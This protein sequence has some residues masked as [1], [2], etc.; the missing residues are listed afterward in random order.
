MKVL[1]ENIFLFL[2]N[3]SA[4]VNKFCKRRVMNHLGIF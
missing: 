3:L 4:R 2:I 1:K